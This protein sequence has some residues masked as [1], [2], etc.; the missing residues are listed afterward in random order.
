ML[1]PNSA[2]IDDLYADFLHD[3][4]SVGEEWRAYFQ[5]RKDA[6]I[7]SIQQQPLQATDDII[8]VVQE[9]PVHKQEQRVDQQSPQSKQETSIPLASSDIP[10]KL[11]SIGMRIA[12]N[13]SQS[14][15]VP[16]A[17]SFRVIPVKALEENR[18][19]INRHLVKNNKKKVSYTH[20]LAWALVKALVK[21]PHMNDAFSVVDGIPHRIK[22]SSVNIGLAVDVTRKDGMRML[23]VPSIKNSQAMTFSDFCAEYDGLISKARANKLS[24]DELSGASISL[25]NPGTIG[26]V[27]SVPRLMEG[28]GLIIA[29]GSIEYPAEFQAVMPDVLSTLAISK[30]LTITS[31]YDHRIIQGAESGEFLAYVHKLVLGEEHFYDQIFANLHI[32][33]EPVRWQKDNRINPFMPQD[34]LESLDK[35]A[36]VAQLINAFRVRGHFLA[37]VNPLGLQAYY[38][39]ELDPA[40]YGFTIWDLD[41]EFDTGGLGGIN[42]ASLRDIIDMLHDTYCG[43][44]GIEYMHVQDPVKER[45]IQKWV[46]PS[47]FSYS[48]SKEQRLHIFKHLT[49][50]EQFEQYL[51]TKYLGSKRFSLEGG[52]TT[53]TFLEKTLELS[54]KDSLRGVVIGMAHR[55]RL[56]VLANILNKPYDKIFDEFEGNYDPNSFE[57]SGD[58]KYHLGATGIYTS[59]TG[60]TVSVMLAPNPSHLEAVNPVVEGMARALDDLI[61]DKD[62]DSHLPILVHGDAAFAGQGV[63]PET[64]N[65]SRLTGYKTGGTIH[66]I[67]NNQIG[68]TTSPDDGRSTPYASDIAK[69]LQVPIIHVNGDD[70]EAVRIAAMFAFE[71]RQKFNDD[72]IVDLFCYRKYGHN[73]TDEP[74]YTQPLLYKKIKAQI[75]VRKQYAHTLEVSGIFTE[76]ELSGIMNEV[77]DELNSAFSARN[78]S[79]TKVHDP[80]SGANILSVVET[81][82]DPAILR[83]IVHKISHVPSGFTANPKVIDLLQKR[84]HMLDSDQPAIDWAMGEALAFGSLL[85]EGHDIRMSGQ[86]CGRGTFSHRHAILRDFQTEEELILLNSLSDKQGQLRIYNSPLS[87]EAV[88]G[89]EFGYSTILVDGLTLWEAQFG[90]FVNGAQVVIDQFISSSEAKWG[91][92]SNLTL[93]LPHGYEGQGPEHSSARLERFLQLCAENNMFVCNFTTPA[94]YFHALRRQVKAPYRKPMIVMSPKEILR[95]PISVLN[96]LLVP[97]FKEIINDDAISQPSSV[98]RVLLCSGKVYY[99]L[100]AERTKLQAQQSVAIIRVEQLYPFRDDMAKEILAQYSH[101]KKVIWVQEEPKNQG[102][103]FFIAPR[104]IETLSA[105]QQLSY[106]GRSEAAS[107]ATGFGKKHEAEKQAFLNTAFQ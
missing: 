52:E 74:S 35:E 28:Q 76:E 78:S 70:P 16:T 38:Y 99:D 79:T 14:L 98:E 12:S 18:R 61:D 17:T 97:S 55:G 27:S 4:N 36:R 62:C 63:V 43:K 19:L 51:H 11:S 66:V 102:S 105:G 34:E 71:Y 101:A 90:D 40:A 23:V 69:M 29:T 94:Q 54:S 83:S 65:L 2:Y 15:N 89:F 56:N 10:E 25:T 107:P 21:Y 48:F 22:R 59:R 53:I 67:I 50:A 88:L 7:S 5:A 75:P 57:G 32:P 85:L 82:V 20:I 106:A 1:T 44:L 92:H 39:P 41:R 72:V 77:K 58:V 24:V 26:T 80:Y 96:D 31:T 95:K 8:E 9:T 45:F 100:I 73:E 6:T 13:M 42:R 46:E 60:E 33:F 93:L 87:E 3:P 91:Q 68:F 30:V 47:R 103:W 37:D 104:L 86:D 81:K 49:K 64:L 84:S